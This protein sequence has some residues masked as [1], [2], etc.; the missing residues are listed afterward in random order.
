MTDR[1]TKKILPEK[2]LPSIHLDCGVVLLKFSF[3]L[4]NYNG[5]SSIQIASK[6]TWPYMLSQRATS[7][8]VTIL[9]TLLKA[10]P[11]LMKVTL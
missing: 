10:N 8:N 3:G 9:Q 7:N 2:L 6:L 5:G 1:L 11:C 4:K